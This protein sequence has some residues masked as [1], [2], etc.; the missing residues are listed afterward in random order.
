MLD[1]K[2][3]VK[4]DGQADLTLSDL[5]LLSRNDATDGLAHFPHRPQT[6]PITR[7]HSRHCHAQRRYCE[8]R[9]APHLHTQVSASL[10]QQGAGNN[11]PYERRHRSNAVHH[12]CPLA[13]LCL[14]ADVIAPEDRRYAG[15]RQ[16]N[17]GARDGAED[18]NKAE[19]RCKAR[20]LCP[21][22][23]D[24]AGADASCARVNVEGAEALRESGG[25]EAAKGRRT[26]HDAEQPESADSVIWYFVG[27]VDVEAWWYILF[28][29]A[30]I[31]GPLCH[32]EESANTCEEH[33][34]PAA[35]ER[36]TY[37]FEVKE[38]GVEAE[39]DEAYCC[40]EPAECRIAKR[41][42]IDPN[43]HRSPRLGL[44]EVMGWVWYGE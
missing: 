2:E 44:T 35:P 27:Q 8:T 16:T 13:Q 30:V 14:A 24:E 4:S 36:M 38:D 41:I 37:I 42:R 25:E 11:R 7:I 22:N 5:T 32:A 3:R 9:P 12:A 10:L 33:S 6:P 28:G 23:E 34:G 21:E 1:C 18:D 26:I 19:S 17:D 40:C 31:G 43:T 39:E 20:G 15:G 29:E